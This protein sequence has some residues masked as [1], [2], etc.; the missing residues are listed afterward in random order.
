MINAVFRRLFDYT[1]K[2]MNTYKKLKKSSK[3]GILFKMR[4]LMFSYYNYKL[5]SSIAYNCKLDDIPHFPHG[6][7]GVFISGGAHIGG[8]ATIFQH[9][10]IGSNSLPDSGNYGCPSIGNSCY[11]GAGA[12]VIGKVNIGNNVRIGAGAV[13]CKDIPDNCV[14]VSQPCRVIQRDNLDNAFYSYKDGELIKH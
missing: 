3:A 4:L 13:V 7:R 9:V 6:A 14:V 10:V 5:G 2:L 1:S 12:K 8:G 11:I